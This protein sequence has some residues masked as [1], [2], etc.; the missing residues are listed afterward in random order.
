MG[1]RTGKRLDYIH[2][3]N[4]LK[5]S[6]YSIIYVSHAMIYGGEKAECVTLRD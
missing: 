4:V 5:V 1:G 3:D 6:N 2:N